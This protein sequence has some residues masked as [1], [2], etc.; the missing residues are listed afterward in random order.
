MSDTSETNHWQH[1]A[2]E[3]GAEAG[4]PSKAPSKPAPA[5]SQ[6]PRRTSEAPRPAQRPAADWSQLATELG[7]TPA[8]PPARRPEKPPAAPMA[9]SRPA[10]RYEPRREA[11]RPPQPRQEPPQFSPEQARQSQVEADKYETPDKYETDEELPDTLVV[12]DGDDAI[13]VSDGAIPEQ[14]NDSAAGE[15]PPKDGRRRRRRRRGRGRSGDR[16]SAPAREAEVWDVDSAPLDDRADELDDIELTSEPSAP[17]ERSEDLAGGE[18]KGRSRRRRRR[19][20]GRRNGE[21]R[22]PTAA[23]DEESQP[24]HPRPSE[25]ADVGHEDDEFDVR[26]ERERDPENSAADEDDDSEL[27]TSHRGIPTWDE[28]IGMII[29]TNMEARAK[30]PSG[31]SGPRGRRGHHRGR[32]QGR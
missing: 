15:R 6:P 25:D 8:S 21:S 4:P 12:E 9:E 5:A 13:D 14:R 16:P 32:S 18:E 17:S 22:K 19:R 3:L 11:P 20:G 30:S 27:K 2:K 23:R 29:G 1:L 28:A 31:P 10:P 24:E 26:P 7:A